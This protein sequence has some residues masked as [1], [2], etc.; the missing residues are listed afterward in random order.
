[1]QTALLLHYMKGDTRILLL[2]RLLFHSAFIVVRPSGF[3]QLYP[4][5]S[6]GS[7]S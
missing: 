7:L 2:D 5:T 3:I 4:E 6:V 1:M